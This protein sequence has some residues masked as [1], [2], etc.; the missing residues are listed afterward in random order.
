MRKQVLIVAGGKGERFGDKIPKQFALIKG[1]PVIVHTIQA[2][3]KHSSDFI[4]VL[5]PAH[6]DLFQKMTEQVFSSL[7]IHLTEGG[8]TRTESVRKGLEMI[9]TEGIVAIHDAVRP[10]VTGRLITEGFKTAEKSGSAVPVIDLKESLREISGE[11]NTAVDRSKFRIVQT[12]QFF[13]SELIKKAYAGIHGSSSDDATVFEKAGH[14]VRLFEGDPS[15]IKITV[16]EDL[17]VAEALFGT[18]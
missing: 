13:R 6:F 1:K 10:L 12:P 8:N 3:I 14:Q 11:T 7:N 16:R 2:F 4:V 15:N 5:P 17:I 18:F 9:D